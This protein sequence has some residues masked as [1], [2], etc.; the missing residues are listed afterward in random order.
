[1]SL[2][3]CFVS[4]VGLAQSVHCILPPLFCCLLCFFVL[5]YTPCSHCI[6]AFVLPSH[7]DL[8]RTRMP[9]HRLLSANERLYL[10]SFCLFFRSGSRQ[11][12][13]MYFAVP[14]GSGSEQTCVHMLL[15]ASERV[16]FSVCCVFVCFCFVVGSTPIFRLRLA[17]YLAV[18]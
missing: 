9:L 14:L 7:R 11:I 12:C 4:C 5:G 13:P 8:Y 18:P 3:L 2:G 17:V 1:M 10:F 15:G 16:L 6:L